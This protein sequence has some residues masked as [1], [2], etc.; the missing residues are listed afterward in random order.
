M[1]A[2]TL[3]GIFRVVLLPL[4]LLLAAIGGLG[5]YYETNDDLIITQLLRGTTAAAPV[6]DLHLYFHGLAAL[7]AALYARF[8]AVPWY[9]L[10]L[11]ALLYAALVLV[12]GVLNRLLK[13]HLTPLRLTLVLVAV[14]G[15]VL[16]ENSLWFNYMRV[17]LLLA[18]AGG[19]FATQRTR[20]AWAL[21]LG[22]L[23]FGVAWLIRPSAA[24]LGLLVVVPGG[25]WLGGRRG[26]YMLAAAL[27]LAGLGGISLTLTRSPA[28]AQF[29]VL[30]LLKSNINDYR[31][32]RPQS[33]TA[34]DSLGVA[35]VSHWILSDSTLV[36]EAFFARTR[37]AGA[38]Y[39]LRGS[40][41]AKLATLGR[42][43]GRDYFPLLLLN[44]FIFGSLLY[45]APTR[46]RLFFWLTQVAFGLL[47][48]SI[49]V[50]LK[51][52]PRL[53]LPLF[54]LFTLGNVIYWLRFPLAVRAPFPRVA[55]AALLLTTGAYGYKT[56]HRKQ[57]L[58][59]EQRHHE[60]YLAALTRATAGGQIL[61]T[62]NLEVAYKS[63][64]PFRVYALPAPQLPL[65]GWATLHP[66]LP[67]FRQQLTGSRDFHLSLRRLA[68][69]PATQWA[70]A[71]EV[72]PFLRRYVASRQPAGAPALTFEAINE[73]TTDTLLPQLYQ[74]RLRLPE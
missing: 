7:L 25:L 22:L 39:L 42:L 58:A 56:L 43:V 28:A 24:V 30:D 47:I 63:L 31:L 13:P 73:I 64:S 29:R 41:P 55:V 23:A 57:L 71:P 70:L 14:F 54:T 48:L 69:R 40:G 33:R 35:A 74:V 62:A 52:P 37:P 11:Y 4:L 53:G 61:V 19:L 10:L 59:A 65:T 21:A 67:R 15:L 1:N 44:A 45:N 12:F 32:Y 34:A 17:P 27:L 6:T 72:V 16:I 60:A 50:G 3:G 49:G 36:N 18:G 8:P 51:L 38:A 68:A 66:S 26:A 2:A 5:A 46:G 9:G 20:H